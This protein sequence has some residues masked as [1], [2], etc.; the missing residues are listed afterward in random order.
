[1]SKNK[2]IE[3][4]NKFELLIIAFTQ[5]ISKAL[6][7]I[8]YFVFAFFLYLAFK[9]DNVDIVKVL[10]DLLMG[11]LKQDTVF[12][13]SVTLNIVFIFIILWINNK[14]KKLDKE[15]KKLLVSGSIKNE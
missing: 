4:K 15:I 12:V 14:N 1:M 13:V 5:I 6:D 3:K 11:V 8:L 2:R 7:K 10:S 9:S